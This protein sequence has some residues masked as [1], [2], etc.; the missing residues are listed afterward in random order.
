[1]SAG[2][3]LPQAKQR[4]ITKRLKIDAVP[5]VDE[6]NNNRMVVQQDDVT[7]WTTTD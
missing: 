2:H 1:M 4:E 5:K 6:M 3:Y 7:I